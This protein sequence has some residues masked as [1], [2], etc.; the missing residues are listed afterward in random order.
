M[1][2]LFHNDNLLLMLTIPPL[3]SDI[4]L[5]VA[6]RHLLSE[7]PKPSPKMG[8]LFAFFN[9]YLC[10]IESLLRIKQRGASCHAVFTLCLEV[11]VCNNAR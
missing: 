3:D 11:R 9:Y 2:V 6:I 7:L 10:E 4:Y 1:V 8:F 5:F